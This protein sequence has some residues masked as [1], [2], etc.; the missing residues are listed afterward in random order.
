MKQRHL[1]AQLGGP[2]K[3]ATPARKAD[4]SLLQENFC[5]A[6][7]PGSCALLAV[8]LAL[9]IFQLDH[10]NVLYIEL[11]LKNILKLQLIQNTVEC[12]GGSLVEPGFQVQFKELVI[13]FKDLYSIGTGY[14]RNHFIL[15]GL[16][17]LTHY[18][19]KSLL[20]FLS[21]KKI[22]L[23]ESRRRTFAFV[24]LSF[25]IFSHQR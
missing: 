25:G 24:A 6:P 12:S 11:S 3:V 23:V 8:T 22:Q 18:N 1:G 13:N 14:L 7:F 19:G 2:S 10:C 15:M 5:V 21:A 16:T 17:L 9:I 4:G 20:W